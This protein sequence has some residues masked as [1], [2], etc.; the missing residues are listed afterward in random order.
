MAIQAPYYVPC[1]IRRAWAAEKRGKAGVAKKVA[2]TGEIWRDEARA[3]TK[4]GRERGR[5]LAGGNSPA[6]T[7]RRRCPRPTRRRA[8]HT[9]RRAAAREPARRRGRLSC[10]GRRCFGRLGEGCLRGWKKGA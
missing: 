7:R 2:G 5:K 8:R 3:G 1:A 6:H 4:R 10:F 9:R